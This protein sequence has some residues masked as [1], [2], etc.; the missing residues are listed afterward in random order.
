MEDELNRNRPSDKG[1]NNDP[2]IRDQD[3][4]QPGTNTSSKSDTDEAN[5]HITKT[6]SDSFRT[7][8]E[9]DERAD[10]SFDEVAEK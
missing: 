1:R 8:T 7:T 10:T 2:D 4:R 6:A 3:A 5:Q 9:D